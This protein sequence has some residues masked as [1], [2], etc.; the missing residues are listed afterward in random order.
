MEPHKREFCYKCDFGPCEE[1]QAYSRYLKK[2]EESRRLK[3]E[4]EI[5]NL[6]NLLLQQNIDDLKKI[7]DRVNSHIIEK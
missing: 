4:D 1:A 2:T 5:N 6:I 3:K 7:L